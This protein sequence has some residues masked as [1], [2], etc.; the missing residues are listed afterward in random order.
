LT[1]RTTKYALCP[2]FCVLLWSKATEKWCRYLHARL[3][4]I[5]LMILMIFGGVWLVNKSGTSQTLENTSSNVI[6]HPDASGEILEVGDEGLSE[7][8]V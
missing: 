4:R 1:F 7:K 3:Q 8:C 2:N 6:V 5:V